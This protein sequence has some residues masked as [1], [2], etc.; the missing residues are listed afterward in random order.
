MADPSLVIGQRKWRVRRGNGDWF[1]KQVAHPT[2]TIEPLMPDF[3][4]LLRSVDIVQ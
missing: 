3:E 4:M 1:A 2:E